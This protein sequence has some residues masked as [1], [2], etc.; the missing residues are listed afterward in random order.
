MT[1]DYIHTNLKV[2]DK[3]EV[4]NVMV[5][6]EY[7][8]VVE[9]KRNLRKSDIDKYFEVTVPMFKQWSRPG[10]GKKTIYVFACESVDDKALEDL[11][12]RDCFLLRPGGKDFQVSRFTGN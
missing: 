7:V 3:T 6:G 5:N 11:E 1:F 2:A 4:D 10:A 9:V 8:G 12:K